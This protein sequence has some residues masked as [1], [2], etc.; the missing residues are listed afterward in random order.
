MSCHDK[1]KTCHP[2]P[3][4]PA[5]FAPGGCDP[6]PPC[7]P[8]PPRPPFKPGCPPS[9]YIGSRYV[10]IFAD[11]IEWD[12]SKAYESLTIV[13]YNGESYTS[14]CNVAPG[15]DITNTTYWAKTGAY[16]AILEQ[17]RTEVSDLSSQVTGF[18]A[19]NKEFREKIDGYD[20]DNTEMKKTLTDYTGKVDKLSE[21][22]TEAETDIDA[23]QA[24]T[25]QHTK[26]IADLKAKDSDLQAQITANDTD[27]A[28]INDHQSEQ[29]SRMDGIESV[30]RQQA[31]AIAK[32]ASDIAAETT[33]ASAAEVANGKLIARNA[34]ELADHAEEL[35]DH[36]KRIT[37]LE[38][39]NVTNKA[40]IRANAAKNVAQDAEIAAAKDAAAHAQETADRAE[41]KA[42][43]NSATI[44]SWEANH[45]GKTISQAVTD[46][47]S[48]IVNANTQI[49]NVK[50]GL[51]QTNENITNLQNTKAD[52]TAL[53]A[54]VKTTVY[55]A[56]QT[57]QDERL[58]ALEGE[59]YKYM[60]KAEFIKSSYAQ[61]AA[62]IWENGDVITNPYFTA[63]APCTNGNGSLLRGAL[64]V[65]CPR[66][67]VTATIPFSKSYSKSMYFTNYNCSI[68]FDTDPDSDDYDT[69]CATALKPILDAA[70]YEP[71][72]VLW[73]YDY[74]Y[75]N[76]V[77]PDMVAA[78]IMV[79]ALDST[80]NLQGAIPMS[81][82][83]YMGGDITTTAY[84]FA[85]LK[86]GNYRVTNGA[87]TFAAV[88]KD[89]ANHLYYETFTSLTFTVKSG[90]ATIP[91]N[92]SQLWPAFTATVLDTYKGTDG[93][94]SGA[95]CYE[96]RFTT[97]SYNPPSS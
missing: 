10:P 15:I 27:I 93:Q 41:T 9:Q 7:P 17:Y 43:A 65:T 75:Q 14:R 48:D 84:T 11:P 12:K 22:V 1:D 19:D 37:A 56:G 83:I 23:L 44:G 4:E 89:V 8:R 45:P 29:D 42:N 78:P 40:D 26:D 88:G 77:D 72:E 71:M 5:P 34:E 25:A 52:K 54:Y 21:R 46:A 3:I 68:G 62:T 94:Y 6:H 36:E 31:E 38:T 55:T 20:A 74:Y 92:L 73:R 69:V 70:K 2:Y 51:S 18:A 64:I 57:A 66:L 49:T 59:Q 81:R 96:L 97:G 30:N 13:V 35:A 80:L 24:T 61:G 67:S 53:D 39:D 50:N 76:N 32:N 79:N 90:M 16:N 95:F 33:R 82:I 86:D 91:L 28:S 63:P 58:T 85:P 60:D 47:N 87:C